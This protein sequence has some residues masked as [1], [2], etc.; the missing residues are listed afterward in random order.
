MSDLGNRCV[1]DAVA[2]HIRNALFERRFEAGAV[3]K[4]TVLA[5][6]YGVARATVRAA[7]Q[8]LVAEG[9]LVRVP[10]HSARVPRYAKADVAD[11]MRARWA[12]EWTAVEMHL[13]GQA[14]TAPAEKALKQLKRMVGFDW[15]ELVAA[16]IALHRAVIEGV[17]SP[18]LL[19][20]FDSLAPELRLMVALLKPQYP[21]ANRLVEEHVQLVAGLV[22]ADDERCHQLWRAH[23]D[24]ALA[25]IGGENGDSENGS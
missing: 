15:S 8:N 12:I 19:Q 3:L 17:G 11:L 14:T 4:D 21:D 5:E 2:S 20:L 23:F 25:M 9:L 6:S 16:D 7:I 13:N 10:G 24:D 22:E 18:H 1:A